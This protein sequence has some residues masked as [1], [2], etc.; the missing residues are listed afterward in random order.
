MSFC[1][2]GLPGVAESTFQKAKE[3]LLPGEK[4]PFRADEE[5]EKV[6]LS[7]SHPPSGTVS[8]LPESGG[9]LLDDGFCDFVF[10]FAQNERGGRHTAKI[11]SFRIRETNL[12]GV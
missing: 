12:K 9:Y 7:G 5:C 2:Q 3:N 10:G 1:T 6:F 8:P 11:K 4:V